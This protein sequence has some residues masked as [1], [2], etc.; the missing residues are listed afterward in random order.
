MASARARRG[1]QDEVRPVQ[2]AV[3]PPAP[4]FGRNSPCRTSTLSAN[5][6]EP[7]RSRLGRGIARRR[8]QDHEAVQ[9]Q[10]R[11]GGR[12]RTHAGAWWQVQ[13]SWRKVELLRLTT[14][15]P[16]LLQGRRGDGG[17]GSR[18]GWATRERLHGLEARDEPDRA[19][20]ARWLAFS[21]IGAGQRSG[22]KR[23]AAAPRSW[24]RRTATVSRR[25]EREWL[26]GES[27][28]KA[29]T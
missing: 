11:R 24:A 21:D 25:G 12:G 15:V 3:P 22:V 8:Q 29:R 1:A 9:V 27:R 17:R 10:G 13:D 7:A 16:S 26:A 20:E 18:R 14:R 19:Y 28:S 5:R 4:P 6:R 2:A 23:S